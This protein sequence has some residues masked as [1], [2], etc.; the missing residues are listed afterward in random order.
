M[1]KRDY[2][3]EWKRAGY[4]EGMGS[5]KFLPPPARDFVRAYHLTSTEHG[6]SSISLRRLKVARFSEVNDPFELIAL[7]FH[8]REIRQLVRRFKDSQNSKTGLLC[9]SANWTSP[10]LWSHYAA[11]HKGICLGFDLRRGNEVQKVLYEEKRPRM[12]LGTNEVPLSIPKDLQ[13]ALLRTKSSYWEY[14]QEFRRFIEL[15]RAKKEQGLYFWPFD[16]DLRL[17][18]VILGQQNDLSLSAIRKLTD[19]TNSDAVVF[20][21]RWAFRSFDVVGDGRYPPEIR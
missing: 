16:K 15:S 11:R 2:E 8:N 18:E 1:T 6:I 5:A 3:Q 4:P 20:K 19:A 17:A 9:F 13:D 12:K 7:N 21:A 10:V 14:E